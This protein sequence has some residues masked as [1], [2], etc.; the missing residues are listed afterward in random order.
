VTGPRPS[1][2]DG[3]GLDRITLF[4]HLSELRKRLAVSLLSVAI[5]PLIGFFLYDAVI[6]FIAHP[7]QDFAHRHP[8]QV[9]T[10]GQMVVTGP[11]GGF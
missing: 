7:H 4:E 9:V 3:D 1:D 8:S 6:H 10:N 2:G 11:R 5:G